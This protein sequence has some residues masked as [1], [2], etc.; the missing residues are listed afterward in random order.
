M[1]GGLLNK[2]TKIIVPFI[3]FIA[4]I[5]LAVRI[6]PVFANGDGNLRHELHWIIYGYDGVWYHNREYL[7]PGKAGNDTLEH[8]ESKYGKLYPTGEKVRGLSVL[9]TKGAIQ[10]PYAPTVLI[11]QKNDTNCIIYALSG[12]P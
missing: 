11:L 6:Y 9:E 3:G 7:G 10:S 1:R 2:K 12:G 5:S 8:L 4:V